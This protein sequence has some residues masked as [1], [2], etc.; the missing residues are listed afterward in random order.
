M[1]VIY[2]VFKKATPVLLK[3]QVAWI[4]VVKTSIF[5]H[6]ILIATTNLFPTLDYLEQHSLSHNTSKV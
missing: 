3:K 1:M 2:H 5:S 4:K 6:Y